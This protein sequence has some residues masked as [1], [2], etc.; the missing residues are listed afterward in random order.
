MTAD[1]RHVRDI[2]GYCDGRLDQ[3][4][5]DWATR[6]LSDCDRCR[7]AIEE[8]R[9]AAAL[10][11]RLDIARAPDSVWTAIES[12][13]NASQRRLEGTRRRIDWFALAATILV[14]IGVAVFFA[15]RSTRPEGQS[16]VGWTVTALDGAIGASHLGVGES[17]E[18]NESS[19]AR[20]NVAELGTVDVDPNT[21][22]KLIAADASQQRLALER[23]SITATISAP[24]R[25]FVV[26]TPSSTVFDLGC[27][28]TMQMD[29]SGEGSVS[30]SVGWISLES[31]GRES[32]VPAGASCETRRGVGPGMPVFDDATVALKRAVRSFDF[33]NGASRAV[34]EVLAACRVRDTLTLW[35]LLARVD[36]VERQQVF[37]RM[38]DLTPLPPEVTRSKALALDPETLRKWREALAWTW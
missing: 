10:V 12:S 28:Y 19:R 31:S 35:H 7:R 38:T 22:V 13:L 33:D 36:G 25:L 21:R 37:D 8:H 3:A 14:G 4:D 32:L 34:N 20:L 24:P 29:E 1:R 16:R 26:D 9:F 23:G 27:Q 5:R 2:A 30:V 15:T 6:H 11:G 18:T 17:L